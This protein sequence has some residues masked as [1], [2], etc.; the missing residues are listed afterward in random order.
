[1]SG[2]DDLG[3]PIVV[4]HGGSFDSQGDYIDYQH[5]PPPNV[6]LYY[7]E[8]HAPYRRYWDNA[9]HN[10][11]GPFIPPK[12][13]YCSSPDSY[14]PPYGYEGHEETYAPHR[15]QPSHQ[16]AAPYTYV[17]QPKLTEKTTLR[18]KFSWKHYPELERF[19][20]ANR[21]E[22]LKHSNMNYTAE[23]KQ[24]NNWLT[25]RLLEVAEQHNYI[26]D[27]EDFNFVAIR[28]RIRCYY[29]SYVQTA[30][31]RGLKLPEKKKD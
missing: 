11:L 1:V 24:Y 31:K 25:E 20:I 2:Y 7:D 14:H 26:F 21:D 8:H 18:K 17:Q 27:P 23:Q 28:D 15:P 13:N 10:R 3:A 4:E 12:W 16:L 30:R 6:P 29:K 19:L 9:H 5:P 22:Y